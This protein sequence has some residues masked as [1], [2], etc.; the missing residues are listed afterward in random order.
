MLFRSQRE[1]VAAVDLALGFRTWQSLTGS[2]LTSAGA[3]DLMADLVSAAA[4]RA[5]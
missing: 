4:A 3:A 1:V 5:G 2:G